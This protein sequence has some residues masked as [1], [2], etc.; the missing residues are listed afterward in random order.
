MDFLV[1][2][3]Q[4]PLSS[5]GEPAVGEFRGSAT[6]PTQSAL[7]G[8]LGAALGL[9]RDAESS[10][11]ALRDG[12]GFAVGLLEPGSLLRDYHTAQV[13]AQSALKGWPHS[14]RR[15][16][17]SA[18]KLNTILST[19]DYRQNASW[20]VALQSRVS[21]DYS[22]TELQAALREPHFPLYLG[23]KSCPPAAP[24][25]PQV[26]DAESALAAWAEYR[27]RHE[28]ALTAAVDKKG[29]LPLE[30]WPDLVQI[31]FDEHV[32]VGLPH[33]LST[34]RK[35]RLIRRQGWQFGDRT[36]H[37]AF[38]TSTKTAAGEA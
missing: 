23:R 21:A 36:E 34:V 30:P 27:R 3:L 13:A 25:W 22:L 28:A 33:S 2:Q 26:I 10:H 20:L 6:H 29:R 15:Q 12:L 8:L 14:T 18:P 35:D 19:R 16:E 31:F 5:W 9:P 24:L 17:L 1:F 38:C 32:Q 7:I 37:V 11:A 4:A